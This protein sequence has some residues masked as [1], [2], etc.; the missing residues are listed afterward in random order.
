MEAPFLLCRKLIHEMVQ[1]G[2]GR[3]VNIVSNTVWAPPG[4]GMVADVTTKGAL[5]A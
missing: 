3:A 4:P 5:W 1:R 2:G